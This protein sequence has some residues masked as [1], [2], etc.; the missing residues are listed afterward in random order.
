MVFFAFWYFILWEYSTLLILFHIDF[1]TQK[2]PD[3]KDTADKQEAN[4]RATEI[5]QLFRRYPRAV[6]TDSED[7]SMTLTFVFE[8]S[9]P[10]WVR[11]VIWA[12]LVR[13]ATTLAVAVYML[14]RYISSRVGTI[15][16]WNVHQSRKLQK[17][18]KPPILGVQ[19]HRWWH[20]LKAR[21]HCLF[22]YAVR[23]H[24]YLQLFSC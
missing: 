7:G 24:P 21:H 13:C 5:Q 6:M 16:L 17:T 8:P 9:D 20:C 4:R 18:L 15:H 10:D 19:G 3:T 1:L 22:W 2:P 11:Q 12:K 14:S 23:L